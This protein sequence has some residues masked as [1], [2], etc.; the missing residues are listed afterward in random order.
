MLPI[1]ESDL[2]REAE[3]A[4][5][6][7]WHGTGPLDEATDLADALGEGRE[8]SVPGPGLWDESLCL[9]TLRTVNSNRRSMIQTEVSVPRVAQRLCP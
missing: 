3:R 8:G 5:F 4:G 7:S 6:G 9:L 2:P 1:H